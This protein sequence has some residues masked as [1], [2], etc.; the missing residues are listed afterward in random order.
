M[1]KGI[2]Q[3]VGDYFIGNPDED[4]TT[5]RIAADTGYTVQQVSQTIHNIRG[6]SRNPLPIVQVKLRVYRLDSS[7]YTPP[8][9]PKVEEAVPTMYELV[10][11]AGAS[12]IVRGD[13]GNLYVVNPLTLG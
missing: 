12:T 6:R 10:G 1:N 8:T 3:R 13:D 5:D 11:K 7:R 2:A 9:P 4:L